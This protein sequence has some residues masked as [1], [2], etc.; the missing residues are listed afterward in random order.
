M[1]TTYAPAELAAMAEVALDQ[2]DCERAAALAVEA[3]HA[4]FQVA[5]R[6]AKIDR[7]G[8][9]ADTAELAAQVAREADPTGKAG[10]RATRYAL[11][12][13]QLATTYTDA[14]L[15]EEEAADG[16]RAVMVYT[17]PACQQCTAT[18]RK[19]T[20]LGVAFVEVDLNDPA[21]A[22]ARDHLI[23]DLGYAAAPVVE[24]D[25]DEHWTGYRPDRLKA[26][27]S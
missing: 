17:A 22:A 14:E 10:D 26:L 16:G 21:N 19:L 20:E 25:G 9:L 1:N 3:A 7:R 5:E 15:R 6:E 11:H 23:N 4:A 13:G 8:E 18:K 2:G 27:A 12:V 24:V